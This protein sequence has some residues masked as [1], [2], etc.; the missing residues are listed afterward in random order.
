M[1]TERA[2]TRISV[3]VGIFSAIA[4]FFSG[5]TSM[6]GVAEAGILAEIFGSFLAYALSLF[7][8]DRLCP[9]NK[10]VLTAEF[11]GILPKETRERALNSG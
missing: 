6:P 5:I 2:A 9:W 1:K 4:I 7:V 8:L 3:I 11:D 10:L